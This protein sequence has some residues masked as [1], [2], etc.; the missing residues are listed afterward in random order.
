MMHD[1]IPETRQPGLEL[2]DDEVDHVRGPTAGRLVLEYGDYEYPYSRHA[3]REIQRDA[4]PQQSGEVRG[5]PT[6]FI[7]GVVHR[8]GHDTATLT[9]ALAG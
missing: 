4:D 2:L 5:T 1:T 8:G 9:E 3:F 6:L 7:D